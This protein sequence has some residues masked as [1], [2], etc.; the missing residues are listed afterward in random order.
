MKAAG[1]V[2]APAARLDEE[3]RPFLARF[4]V[5]LPQPIHRMQPQAFRAALENSGA[6]TGSRPSGMAVEDRIAT[7]AGRSVRVRLYR[8]DA[9]APC[10]RRALLFFHGGG[11]M[12]GS[13]DSYDDIAADIAAS[14]SCTVISV[15]YA[16]APE[17]RYPAALLDGEAV[18]EWL[19][20]NLD[21]LDLDPGRIAIGGD[22]AGGNLAAALCLAYRDRG[23][24]MPFCFQC[25]LYPALDVDVERP[26]YRRNADAPILGR[27]T[28]IWFLHHY[29]G[30]AWATPDVYA[31]PLRAESLAGMPPA[32]VA[33]AGFDPLLDEGAEYAARLAAA[34]VPCEYRLAGDLV[35]GFLRMRNESRRARAE[36]DAAC[37]ALHRA[38]S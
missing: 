35:H 20:A 27:E 29:L 13:V 30:E 3:I 26:S 10:R 21:G 16:L 1:A 33:G 11:W 15:E 17:H 24:A 37:A 14:A 25:L 9:P 34:D 12:V 4:E 5:A 23:R 32:F 6:G 8:P 38:L 19:Y 31:A 7:H 28:M 36:F 2:A 18:A 22:S